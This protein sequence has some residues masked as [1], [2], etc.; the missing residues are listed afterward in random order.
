MEFQSGT[1][2]LV[3]KMGQVQKAECLLFVVVLLFFLF[4]AHSCFSLY[5]LCT[6]V[7]LCSRGTPFISIAL[8]VHKARGS[9]PS[10]FWKNN[11]ENKSGFKAA[12][13]EFNYDQ[14]EL[15]QSILLS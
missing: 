8:Q 1:H 9:Q 15:V 3:E 7:R 6:A 11:T 12:F 2:M 4:S 5:L 14:G 10:Y 13:K